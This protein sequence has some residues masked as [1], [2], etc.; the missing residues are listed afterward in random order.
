MDGYFGGH[1]SYCRFLY[2]IVWLPEST[3]WGALHWKWLERSVWTVADIQHVS[4]LKNCSILKKQQKHLEMCLIAKQEVKESILGVL[5][6]FCNLSLQSATR[7]ELWDNDLEK[8]FCKFSFTSMFTLSYIRLPNFFVFYLSKIR[9]KILSR[10]I[11]VANMDNTVWSCCG[12][13]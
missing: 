6:S 9:W 1:S 11:F 2:F 7:S 10:K 8:Q 13:R 3:R 12:D 5:H 4:T